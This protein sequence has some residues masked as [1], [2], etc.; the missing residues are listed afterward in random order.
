MDGW[1]CRSLD[2]SE[3]LWISVLDVL[4]SWCYSTLWENEGSRIMDVLICPL[5]IWNPSGNTTSC[6]KQPCVQRQICMTSCASSFCTGI[7]HGGK[8][9]SIMCSALK[10]MFAFEWWQG[11]KSIQLECG[12][13]I[14]LSSWATGQRHLLVP[15]RR[16]LLKPW[17]MVFSL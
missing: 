17:T 14:G 8:Q 9:G 13:V 10:L 4:S 5:C 3:L 2:I 1:S 7:S 15:A 12:S 16:A 6:L 11:R